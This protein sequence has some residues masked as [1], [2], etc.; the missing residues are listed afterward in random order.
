MPQVHDE[1]VLDG[2]TDT[3]WGDLS[4]AYGPAADVPGLLRAVAS[5][6]AMAARDA[7]R[8]LFGN[9]W[10]QGTVYQATLPAVPFLAR[11]AAAGIVAGGLLQLLG[12]IAEST[13]DATGGDARAAVASEAGRLI[14]CCVMPTP[15]SVR[16]RPGGSPGAGRAMRC[17]RRC[18]RSGLLRRTR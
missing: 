3:P 13:D 16:W 6:D 15:K 2:L 18:R 4:H 9:I 12:C 5:G 14:P 1:G 7:V 10:H 17:S 8:E 11:M